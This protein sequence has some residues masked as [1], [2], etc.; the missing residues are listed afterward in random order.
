MANVLRE[1]E[2]STETIKRL[3]EQA[4]FKTKL[5]KDGDLYITDGLDFPIWVIVDEEQKLIR[6]TTWARR[7]A[8]SKE[9]RPYSETDSNFLNQRII[10]P[11]FHV[12]QADNP[13]LFASYF[14]SYDEG[15]IDSHIVNLARRFA[16]AFA[17]GGNTLDQQNPI[18]V[19]H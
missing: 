18:D 10:L 3:F 13:R 19:V 16:G 12:D 1:D 7:D 8:D 5:D 4:F 17:Y 11:S 9:S 6:F 15:V 2:V 14:I